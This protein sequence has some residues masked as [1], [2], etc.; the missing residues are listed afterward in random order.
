MG[1]EQ[2]M[3]MVMALTNDLDS[4]AIP[5]AMIHGTVLL[6]E[7]DGS[8]RVRLADGRDKHC[9]WLDTGGNLDVNLLPGDTVLVF[10]PSGTTAAVVLGRVGL[11]R[12]PEGPATPLNLTVEATETLTLKCGEAS[13]DLRKDGKLMV[14]GE[15][16]LLRSKGTH[17]IKAGTVAIN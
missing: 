14:R 17:R 13:I 4:V 3:A 2:A 10:V 8:I 1:R 12:V 15:D 7:E 16:I 9:G 11:Y 5:A 6:I